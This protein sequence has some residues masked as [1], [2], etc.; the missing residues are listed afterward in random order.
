MNRIK[1]LFQHK[2]G[3]ILNVYFT[4]GYPNLN[5]TSFIIKELDKA[6]TDLIEVGMPYS[7]PLADGLTIQQSSSVALAN[8][9]HLDLLFN[10]IKK[11][12][13]TSQ[14]PLVLMGYFNQLMQYGVEKFIARCVDAGVDGLI[15]PDLPLFEYKRDF[16][17]LFEEN[18]IAIS[19]LITP[20]TKDA[21]V[22]EIDD[23]TSGFVY[24]V[25]S[26]AT[27]G[28]IADSTQKQ[29]EYYERIAAM[30]LLNP[31]LIGFGIS[32]H[33]SF[34]NACR[35][36]HGAIIGSAF[37]RALQRGGANS[38]NIQGFI[39]QIKHPQKV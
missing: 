10:Q 11:A 15:L 26:N 34:A 25:S 8:G 27:T 16:K 28:G 39:N 20:L 19:F 12:R 22:R 17:C 5:D 14:I 18:G 4:A 33:E 31:R 2:K 7:D 1:K 23:L 30:N 21:R 32:D 37:I 36:A 3:D 29:I 9:M 13:E 24:M 35:Y 6:G 38:A